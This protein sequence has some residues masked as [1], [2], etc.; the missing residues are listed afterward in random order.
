[1]KADMRIR[2]L[3]AGLALVLTACSA[4]TGPSEA[5]VSIVLVNGKVFT[6]DPARPWVEA[7]AISGE[8]LAAVGT[9]AD[10]RKLALAS[11]RVVDLGG[12]TVIPGINDAHVHVPDILRATRVDLSGTSSFREVAERLAAAARANSSGW[13]RG[14]V[15]FE[16]TLLDDPAATRAGLD[17][18]L[19]SQPVVLILVDGHAGLLNS[20]AL[21]EW[22]IS[23][24]DADP[25]AGWYGR[26]DGGRLTGWLY[27]Y[28]FWKKMR[29]AQRGLPDEEFAAALQAFAREAARLGITSVQNMSMPLLAARGVAILQKTAPTI[30]WR[31]IRF[32]MGEVAA[33]T[34]SAGKAGPDQRIR[35]SGIKYILDGTPIERGAAFREP[36]ADKPGH[37]GRMNFRRAQIGKMIGE[38]VK[39]GEPLLL[40][41]VGDRAVSE[42]LEEL[43]AAGGSAARRP[44]RVRFEHADGISPDLLD[45][46][47]QQGVI[48]VQNPSHFTLAGLAEARLGERRRWYM[49]MRSLLERGIPVALGSDGP[50]NPY[51]NILFAVTHPVNPAEALTREQ[52][53]AA[54]TRGSAYA[55]SAE[56]EKGT[57]AP[58]MLA[59]LAVLSQDIFTIPLEQLPATESVLTIVGGRVIHERPQAAQ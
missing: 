31:V 13:L 25:P 49:P 6:A 9:T 1:M 33:L 52:A 20:A 2:R 28:A 44:I 7:V 10:V 3:L 58:G 14:D 47:K 15:P 57:L 32:Q 18:L 41:V 5:P 27:E 21:R 24:S 51:L 46:V 22:S 29:E 56:G 34:P 23:E 42:A 12:R 11:T 30:R 50:L 45:E 59:D 48:V 54:Y 4:A 37:S 8:R 26:D 55:E 40:H 36:Y 39:A 38:S 35:A 16:A 19:P 17:A 53:V 43:R